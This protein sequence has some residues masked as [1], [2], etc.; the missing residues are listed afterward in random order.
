MAPQWPAQPSVGVLEV[1]GDWPAQL[2]EGLQEVMN[3]ESLELQ[4]IF[5]SDHMARSYCIMYL[6]AS[7]AHGHVLKILWAYMVYWM[8][9]LHAIANT[10]GPAVREKV[11]VFTPVA[12]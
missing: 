1:P 3:A 7:Y 12:V 5:K 6:H 10:D 9:K 8:G 2:T 4:A 11:P